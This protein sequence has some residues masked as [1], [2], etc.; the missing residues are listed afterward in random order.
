[1]KEY[2]VYPCVEHM[3]CIEFLDGYGKMSFK[4]FCE[5]HCAYCPDCIVID[6]PY[7]QI[8]KKPDTTP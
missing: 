6:I 5:T 4:E 3:D 1:M 2:Y 7:D 8:E